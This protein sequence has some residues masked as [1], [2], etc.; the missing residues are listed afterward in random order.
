MIYFDFFL[1]NYR[2]QMHKI[3]MLSVV[4]PI[5]N[6]YLLMK[7]SGIPLL[8]KAANK[9]W[10]DDSKYKEYVSQTNLLV[11]NPFAVPIN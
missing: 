11:P 3:Q 2:V 10:K 4:C 6:I 7:V 5:F 1:N 9:K 8:E